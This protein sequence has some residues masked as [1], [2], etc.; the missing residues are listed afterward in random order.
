MNNIRLERQNAVATVWLNR[1]EVRNAFNPDLIAELTVL[2]KRD[3]NNDHNLRAIVLRGEG[4]TFCAGADLGWMQSMVDYTLAENV[5][6]SEKLFRMFQTLR[7]CPVPMIAAVHGHAMGGAL[8]LLAVCDIVG[9]DVGT[10]FCFSEA[11]LG[12]APAVISPFVLEKMHH[13]Q[14]HRF[15]L[16]AE[17]F[18]AQDAHNSGLVH[19]VGSAMEV[20]NFVKKQVE[21]IH[22]N[23][24]EAVRATKSLLR[25]SAKPVDW[26]TVMT[27]TTRVIA[28]RRVSAE[29]QEG[30]KSFFAKNAPKWRVKP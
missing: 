14:A 9:A 7:E 11:K 17:V 4:K 18:S 30:L 5:A 24:P 28:E 19:F 27:E 16:T 15:M 8:G 3:L 13:A 2:F 1:P 22:E 26:A 10:Q 29:G 23:G 6:D 12:L 25:L 20:E 21:L